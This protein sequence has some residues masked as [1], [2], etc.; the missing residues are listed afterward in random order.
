MSDLF[1]FKQFEVDQSGCAMKI[2]TD[3]VLLGALAGGS[4]PESILDIGTGTGVI[5]MMM[6]QRFRDA[7]ID[8]VEIDTAAA[9]TAGRNFQNSD[10]SSRLR[11]Y[12]MGFNAY[13]QT[14]PERQ[15]DL[16]ISNPPF[17]IN[18]LEA[19]T[20]K[21]NLAKHTDHNFFEDLIKTA[22]HRLTNKGALWLVLPVSTSVLVKSLAVK[23]QL[24][25][26]HQINIHSFAH[27]DAH[28]EIILL[29]KS[30]T[31]P[32]ARRFIIYDAPKV[33]SEQYQE[34]LRDFFTIF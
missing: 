8:A 9:E 15:Y 2:N 25:V 27:S 33:Y 10:F 12:A 28:R 3:G 24:F 18:S 17:Y 7:R 5:A 6:A 14:Y 22:F 1:K 13:F 20:S 32:T 11:V 26:E 21:K 23:H 29:N 16:I 31:K 4:Q 30:Q 19:S 34:C